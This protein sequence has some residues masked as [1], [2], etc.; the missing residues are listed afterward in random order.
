MTDA[1]EA[2]GAGHGGH[3]ADFVQVWLVIWLVLCFFLQAPN[4]IPAWE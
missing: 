4:S 1:M 2:V 3:G